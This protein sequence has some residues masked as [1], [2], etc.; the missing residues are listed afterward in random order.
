ML[1]AKSNVC[2]AAT[3]ASARIRAM[4]SRP[5]RVMVTKVSAP[6]GS[7][8]VTRLVSADDVAGLAVG[9]FGVG[10]RLGADAEEDGLALPGGE[11]GL[12]EAQA[13]G[14]AVGVGEGGVGVAVFHDDRR[15]DDVHRGAAHEGGHEQVRGVS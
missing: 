8:T 2:P 15:G 13:A 7:V 11:V 1:T 9:A 12:G 6:A 10:D 14:D 5:E 3:E 4:A